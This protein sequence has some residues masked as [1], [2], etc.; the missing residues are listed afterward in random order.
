MPANWAANGELSKWPAA[1]C[2][3]WYYSWERLVSIWVPRYPSYRTQRGKL[4]LWG[5]CLDTSGGSTSCQ[6]ADPIFGGS[7]AT[8]IT[9][10]ARTPPTVRINPLLKC[11]Y[12]SAYRPPLES[13]RSGSLLL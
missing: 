4:L 1:P 10:P 12:A 11:R 8:D 3:G 7:G 6:V 5:F 2:P 9:R 13:R